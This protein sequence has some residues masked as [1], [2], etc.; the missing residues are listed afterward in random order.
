MAQVHRGTMSQAPLSAPSRGGHYASRRYIV[1]LLC[2]CKFSAELDRVAL[3]LQ[4]PQLLLDLG[5]PSIRSV[6]ILPPLEV[7]PIRKDGVGVE[8][9]VDGVVVIS[10]EEKGAN[11]REQV[12]VHREDSYRYEKLSCILL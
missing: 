4:V 1:R 3:Y 7:D 12:R 5:V 6:W 10:F 2:H 8:V 9:K 11:L